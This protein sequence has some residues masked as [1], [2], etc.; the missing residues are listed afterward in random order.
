MNVQVVL[1]KEEEKERKRKKERYLVPRLMTKET[2]Y[3]PRMRKRKKKKI[4]VL[5]PA[6]EEV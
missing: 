2:A 3:F 4:K 6:M 1:E 5:G